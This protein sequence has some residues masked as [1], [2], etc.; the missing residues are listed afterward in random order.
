MKM[1]VDGKASV[2]AALAASGGFGLAQA[3]VMFVALFAW[4]V[5]GAQVMSMAYVAPAAA[6]EFSDDATAI[7][8]T[9]TFFF[10]GWLVGLTLWGRLS[11]TRGWL[12]ALV[13]IELAVAMSGLATAAATSGRMYLAARFFC[14]FAEGGVP[15]TSF[16]WAGEFFLPA[17]KPVAGIT[18]QV[19][20]LVG[21]LLITLGAY[22]GGTG[23][24]RTLSAVVSACALPVALLAFIAP[25]SPRWLRRAG[26]KVRASEVLS[27]IASLNSWPAREGWSAPPSIEMHALSKAAHLR[28]S[29]KL[30]DSDGDAADGDVELVDE[31]A[32]MLQHAHAGGTDGTHGVR[33]V[34]VEISPGVSSTSSDDLIPA[35][36][37]PVVAASARP[38]PSIW[39]L[40]S[41][42]ASTRRVVLTLCFH[43]FVYSALFFGLSLHQAHDVRNALF[44]N[45]LQIPTVIA[46]AFAFDTLGRRATMLALLSTASLA[47]VS[48]S[49]LHALG[50]ALGSAE[51]TTRAAL[52]TL[53]CMCMSAAFAGGYV[54]S[55]ELLPTE[56]RPIGLALCS[57]CSRVGGMMSPVALL[58]EHAAVP[59]ALWGAL[60]LVGGLAT[61][62][63]PET[64]GEP[65]L[66]TIDDLHALIYRRLGV[67][68]GRL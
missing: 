60:A 36:S 40:I 29:E 25:E 34:G 38:T 65:S 31:N 2:D 10:T 12:F 26:H 8:L 22:E 56:V 16:G 61:L 27:H 46:T 66:E 33:T 19:G 59:Y 67:R 57:Q 14:G 50:G 45:V 15:T 21:S 30:R 41:A 7:R 47:C 64:L 5:H 18:L 37:L 53:G 52:S 43:W 35:P 20:F 24:W 48:L 11:S 3:L 63:L 1:P 13:W 9:G 32:S 54:L 39:I 51:E 17:H 23:E 42:D 62:A 55:A 4:I 28:D 6:A 58:F 68:Y 44:T 49:T